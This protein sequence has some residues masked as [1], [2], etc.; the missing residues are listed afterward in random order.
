MR[1]PHAILLVEV[2]PAEVQITQPALK[3]SALAVELIV[4]RDGPEAVD[5]LLRRGAH[6]DGRRW[7]SPDLIL[8]DLD[9]PGMNG[10][11]VLRR[12]RTTA[13]LCTVPVVALTTSGRHEDIHAMYAA[14]ANTYI[15]KPGDFTRFVEVMATIKPYW[16]DT[17]SLPPRDYE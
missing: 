10:R 6:A 17:A 2:N 5:Y 11:D 4:V 16:L 7:R 9:L 3:D 8:L 13:G 15:E 12:I 14:G 1:P